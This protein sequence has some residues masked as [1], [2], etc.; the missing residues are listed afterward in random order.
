MTTVTV[1]DNQDKLGNLLFV[2]SAL[3]ELFTHAGATV[4][5]EDTGGRA[6]LTVK[7]EDRFFEIIRAE[8]ADKLGEVIAINY[9]YDFFKK[10]LSV[11]GLNETE[12][13]I[14]LTSLIAADLGDDKKYAARRFLDGTDSSVDGIF[15]FRL[16]ALKRKWKDVASYMPDVFLNSQLKDFIS[17][18]LE[19]KKKRVY[20]DGGK[21][22]DSHYRRLKRCDLLP[23][24][25]ADVV[26]EVILSNC[27]EVELSG[28]IN[29]LDEKYL[30]EYYGDKIIFS[31]GY[32]T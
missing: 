13:E 26:R 5:T 9:K 31:A 14:L 29:E 25:G 16:G 21:V 12:N 27:G 6:R 18:L 7:I 17:Y 32:L 2:K 11:S 23:T 19:N 10:T 30:K 24:K 15:N 1:T 20:I 3:G 28:K 22:Y 8:I 4:E